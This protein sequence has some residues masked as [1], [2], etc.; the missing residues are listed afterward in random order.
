VNIHHTYVTSQ[1][2]LSSA[3]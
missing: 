2:Y 1:S 3:T